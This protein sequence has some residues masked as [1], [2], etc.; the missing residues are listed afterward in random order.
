MARDPRN[1]NL[2]DKKMKHED[3]K[4]GLTRAEWLKLYE[5]ACWQ[6]AVVEACHA[7]ATSEH[8][9]PSARVKALDPWWSKPPG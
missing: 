2:K 8:A 7:V 1:T 9:V 6:K 4:H 5:D 3:R